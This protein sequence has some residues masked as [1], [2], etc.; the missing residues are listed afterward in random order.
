MNLKSMIA[1]K[2]VPKHGGVWAALGQNVPPSGLVQSYDGKDLF[3]P[4][5][6]D[7]LLTFSPLPFS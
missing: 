5:V 6:E 4:Y 7:L 2:S 3:F 1:T